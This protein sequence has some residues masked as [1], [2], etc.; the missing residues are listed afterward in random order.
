MFFILKKQALLDRVRFIFNRDRSTVGS[1]FADS[2]P[3]TD[4]ARQTEMKP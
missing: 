1:W 3:A 4:Y 2:V